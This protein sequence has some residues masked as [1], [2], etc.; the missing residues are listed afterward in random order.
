M[1]S[2]N[3]TTCVPPVKL[4]RNEYGLLTH[5][6]YLF[7]EEGYVDWRRMLKPEHL[8]INKQKYPNQDVSLLDM[9][10]VP[11]ENLLILLAGIKYLANLRGFTNV[12]YK[13][14]AS[15]EDRVSV[16]CTI[17]WSANY[18][19]NGREINFS[20][21]ADATPNNTAKFATNYLTTI[22]ENRAFVRCVRN[23][24]RIPIL[25]QEEISLEEVEPVTRKAKLVSSPH[26]ILRETMKS[27]GVTFEIIK[28]SVVKSGKFPPASE[29][30][31]VDSIP[32]TMC[33]SLINELKKK[34]E[35]KKLKEAIETP[36]AQS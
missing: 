14:I 20:S 35:S 33:L 8:V 22:A 5:V 23:F 13:T 9:T 28:N 24:L 34:I 6:D 17:T 12:E 30:K 27:A 16:Q 26:N 3:K 10:E 36:T 4:S 29:W 2:T 1:D 32:N 19:T 18:E 31:N 21:L 15:T 7:D 25:S 11:E